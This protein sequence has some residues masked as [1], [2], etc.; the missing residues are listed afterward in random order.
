M[1]VSSNEFEEV[2]GA[3]VRKAYL[4][5]LLTELRTGEKVGPAGFAP[6]SSS[7]TVNV[8]FS[9]WG[10]PRILFRKSVEGVLAA[11]VPEASK[12]WLQLKVVGQNEGL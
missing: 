10:T 1:S 9:G 11:Q 8:S 7:L 3:R 2:R 5:A 12:L 6:A 4:R